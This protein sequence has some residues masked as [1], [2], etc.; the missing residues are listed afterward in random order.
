MAARFERTQIYLFT[1]L[2]SYVFMLTSSQLGSDG[3]EHRLAVVGGKPGRRSTVS[4]YPNRDASPYAE[5]K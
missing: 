5:N 3:A 2:G 1:S 4:T